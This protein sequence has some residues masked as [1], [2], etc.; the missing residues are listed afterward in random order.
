V[1]E[2]ACFVKLSAPY[3]FSTA[4]PPWPDVAPL[5]EA[6]IEANPH[7]C[8]WGTDWP[9]VD[10]ASA[11]RTDDVLTALSTWCP[12]EE[13]RRIVTTNAASRLFAPAE[14][15]AGGPGWS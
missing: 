3:R 9:H 10:T 4:R 8:L 11:V 1:R 12:D 7:A 15:W 6:F 2:G 13:L 14:K 5:A